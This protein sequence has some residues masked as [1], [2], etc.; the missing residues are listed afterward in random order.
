MG[1]TAF[2][3]KKG[4]VSEKWCLVCINKI[5]KLALWWLFWNKKTKKERSWE[6][7]RPQRP[8][9][10]L[11]TANT[12]A[13][14]NKSL[15]WLNW[16]A[17]QAIPRR[18][19]RVSLSVLVPATMLRTIRRIWRIS[20]RKG[21]H[22]KTLYLINLWKENWIWS[23]QSAFSKLN[24]SNMSSKLRPNL[25]WKTPSLWT[26]SQ[27]PLRIF[28]KLMITFTSMIRISSCSSNTQI[29]SK[30]MLFTKKTITGEAPNPI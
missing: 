17:I 2:S 19:S 11:A 24:S 18:Y 7:S 1:G 14:I 27:E 28:K 8:R 16:I 12:S 26:S 9:L 21:C 22:P 5:I 3:K 23:I 15:S 30:F 20:S 4:L 29:L 6:R 13:S 25:I 10:N